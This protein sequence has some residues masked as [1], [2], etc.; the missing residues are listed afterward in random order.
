[1]TLR[2]FSYGGGVQSTAALV[3]AAE[4]KI[5]FG[6]F[7]FANVGEKSEAKHTLAYVREIAMPYAAAHG[8]ALHELK[9]TRRDGTTEDL[10]ERMTR[11]GSKALT[12]PMRLQNGMPASRSC[13]ADFKIAV[14]A[15]WEKQRG[16]T[17]DDPAVHGLGISLDEIGRA[18]TDSGIPH[19]TLT[20]PLIDA[21]L[22]RQDCINIIER[23]GLPLPKRS[24]C[25][26]CP[27]HSRAHW[28]ETKRERPEEFAAA[29]EL[30]RFLSER[31]ERLGH[32]PVY[33]TNALI[34]LD[35]VIVDTG[36]QEFDLTA[37]DVCESGYCM[38]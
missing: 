15:R 9:R 27:F 22:T 13:T 8:I 19:Q 32:G 34:P 1:M 36:Q 14:V 7:L 3:L 25:W 5:D 31:S 35:Q 33:M 12:I 4:G 10:Y 24:A 16:A 28:L 2:C 6:I 30:E 37:L 23:A 17:A 29:V 18:R 21:R 26:H 11:E 38:T 20:Y